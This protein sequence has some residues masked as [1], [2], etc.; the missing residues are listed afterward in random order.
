MLESEL[1][2]SSKQECKEFLVEHGAVLEGEQVVC[3]ASL[4]GLKSSSLV[5]EQKQDSN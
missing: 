5:S 2:F 4:D 1:G 3:R